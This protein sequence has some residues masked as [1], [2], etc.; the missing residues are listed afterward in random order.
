MAELV[1]AGGSNIVAQEKSSSVESSS[2]E[3]MT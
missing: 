3:V 2:S 1:P